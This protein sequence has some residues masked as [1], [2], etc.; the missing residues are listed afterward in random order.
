L[1]FDERVAR[2]VDEDAQDG[3]VSRVTGKQRVVG[4]KQRLGAAVKRDARGVIK[5]EFVAR[6][7]A[8]PSEFGAALTISRV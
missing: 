4:D 6:L 7:T 8:D 2:V 3:E 1:A 5:C